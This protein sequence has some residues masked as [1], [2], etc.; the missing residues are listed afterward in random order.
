ME[1]EQIVPKPEE[2]A[3]QTQKKQNLTTQA[4]TEHKTVPLPLS[5]AWC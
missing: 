2:G 4:C 3:A 5:S 1:K